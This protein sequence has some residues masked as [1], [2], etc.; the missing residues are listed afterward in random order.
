MGTRKKAWTQAIWFTIFPTALLCIVF[1]V[2]Y[3]AFGKPQC[4]NKHVIIPGTCCTLGCFQLMKQKWSLMGCGNMGEVWI[5]KKEEMPRK[6]A[7]ADQASI[8]DSCWLHLAPIAGRS[9]SETWWHTRRLLSHLRWTL[10][11]GSGIIKFILMNNLFN[12][13]QV[14]LFLF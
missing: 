1:V 5:S 7:S 8:Q 3:R 4:A 14:K 2:F 11:M 6:T 12:E 9:W 10:R 13:T